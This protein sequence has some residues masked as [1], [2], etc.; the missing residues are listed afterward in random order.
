ML[1]MYLVISVDRVEARPPVATP[2]QRLTSAVP[3]SGRDTAGLSRLPEGLTAGATSP[4]PG[5]VRVDRPGVPGPSVSVW[6]RDRP[7]RRA[8]GVRR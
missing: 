8:R 4:R 5:S 3:D 2:G 1:V 6:R 7:W